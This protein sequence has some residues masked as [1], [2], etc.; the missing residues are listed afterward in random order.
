MERQYIDF[1]VAV[2]G[3]SLRRPKTIVAKTWIS[4]AIQTDGVP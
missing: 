1:Q 2:L 4:V 3:F